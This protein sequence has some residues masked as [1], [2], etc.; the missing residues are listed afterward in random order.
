ME[1]NPDFCFVGKSRKIHIFFLFKS[2]FSKGSFREV[3]H[4]CNR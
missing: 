2:L 4:E 1:K 3:F